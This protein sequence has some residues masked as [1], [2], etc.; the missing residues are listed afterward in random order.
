MF[1]TSIA[2]ALLNGTPEI[3][4]RTPRY[5][6]MFEFLNEFLCFLKVEL[7]IL[8]HILNSFLSHFSVNYKRLAHRSSPIVPRVWSI[9]F[10]MFLV[11][12]NQNLLSVHLPIWLPWTKRRDPD[13][14]GYVWRAKPHIV[15]I[16]MSLL[17][18]DDLNFT[19][20]G[21]QTAFVMQPSLVNDAACHWSS[22][23]F[24][25]NSRCSALSWNWQLLKQNVLTQWK[26]V[27]GLSFLQVVLQCHL[28]FFHCR[29]W[30]CSLSRRPS[31]ITRNCAF[32]SS[33][34]SPLAALGTKVYQVIRFFSAVRCYT[35]QDPASS[36]A[37][38]S[39]VTLPRRGLVWP[40]LCVRG[41][42][43]EDPVTCVAGTI[44]RYWVRA[45][46]DPGPVSWKK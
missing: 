14:F 6:W 30:I 43:A 38:G 35:V 44:K 32:Y 18:V 45:G 3:Q 1:F 26:L 28:C 39:C 2:P 16:R 15:P 34:F 19:V 20:P 7:Q 46:E 4:Q 41:R 8:D 13:Y 10:S 27:Q 31:E 9:C 36:R 24:G 25:R 22:F 23:G 5:W 33:S 42:V 17:I 21:F 40:Y 12:G 11:A 37:T 29:K